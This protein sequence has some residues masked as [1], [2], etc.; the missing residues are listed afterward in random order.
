MTEPPAK[1]PGRGGAR[2]GAGRKPTR[3]AVKETAADVI[4]KRRAEGGR[5]PMQV[6]LEAMDEMYERDGPIAAFPF[7]QACAP[8]MHPKL[9]SAEVKAEAL[10]TTRALPASVHEFV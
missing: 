9:A 10:I 2:P 8:F 7:A 3:R 5:E 1:K 4:L 6:M